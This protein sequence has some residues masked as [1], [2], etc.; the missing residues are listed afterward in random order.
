MVPK[1]RYMKSKHTK[2]YTAI[3]KISNKPNG[4]AYCVK[5]RFNDLIKFTS[6]LDSKWRGWKWFNVYSNKGENKGVQLGNFS[7]KNR[8][9]RR[10]I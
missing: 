10:H 8:P 6:F 3:V 9:I 7:K 4:A 2:R 5:Y 1:D